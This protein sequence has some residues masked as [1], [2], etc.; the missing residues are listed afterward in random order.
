MRDFGRGV[1]EPRW[2]QEE[3]RVGIGTSRAGI[4]IEISNLKFEI[5]DW[6]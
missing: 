4:R 2:G 3:L 6:T 1:G 5:R